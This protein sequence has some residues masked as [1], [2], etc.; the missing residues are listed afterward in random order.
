MKCIQYIMK[1][2][3]LL[4]KDLLE[5][6]RIKFLNICLQYQKMC[7]LI[8]YMILLYHSTIKIKPS[9]YIDSSKKINHRDH[10]FKT[11]D[12]I[13]IS[14]YKNI[15][16]KGYIPN[17]SEE[18]FVIKKVKDTLPWR[19]IT[20]YLRKKFLECFTKTNCKKQIKKNL[21]LKK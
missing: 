18:V 7:I 4:L 11:G 20:N 19:C 15:F 9:K 12:I 3:M 13:R 5:P 8:N 6:S 1:K 2:N 10:K 16:A 17:C 21:E 14:K